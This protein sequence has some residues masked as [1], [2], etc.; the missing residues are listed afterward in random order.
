MISG[1][2]KPL[3]KP[4]L[5]WL[6]SIS[7]SILRYELSTPDRM[8]YLGSEDTFL[9]ASDY[10]GDHNTPYR[11]YA[12]LATAVEALNPWLDSID[13]LRAQLLPQR[14]RMS[15]KRL[16]DQHRA[17]ALVPF[18]KAADQ[19]PGFL[20]A[21]AISKHSGSFLEPARAEGKSDLFTPVQHW[22]KN[23]LEELFRIVSCVSLL[24]AGLSRP[25]HDVLWISDEDAILANETRMREVSQLLGGIASNLLEHQM[26]HLRWTTTRY[27]SGQMQLEDIVAIPDLVAGALLSLL[28]HPDA[29]RSET[30]SLDERANPILWWLTNVS[31]IGS[32]I[33]VLDRDERGEEGRQCSIRALNLTPKYR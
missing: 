31:P 9:V 14:R 2:W 1:H 5:G 28:Q 23:T 22:K 26:G 4:S 3:R 32:R 6:Q 10:A 19:I 30:L 7:D 17:A 20:L 16:G 15:F 18:L 12:F 25:G 33:I 29:L 27:D 11:V 24:V 13:R 8:P 21:V